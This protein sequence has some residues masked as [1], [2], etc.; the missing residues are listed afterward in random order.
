MAF[1]GMRHVVSALFNT[2]TDGSA[3]TYTSGG[4]DVGKAISGNLTIERNNNPL[5]A[6]DEIA[7]DDAG[8][9]AISLELGTDDLD[10]DVQDF[11]G[12]LV[13]K[14]A[15]SP[16]VTTYYESDKGPK[17]VGVGYMRVRR[18][19]GVTTYQGIWFYKIMFSR[20]SES[21]QTKGQSIEWKTPTITGNAIA[22]AVDG[23]GDKKFREIR[24]F[25]SASDC[26]SWLDTKAGITR[27]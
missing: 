8:V 18:K 10:E 5:Y 1:I 17:Y 12:L 27:T 7:E 6:D 25:T 24:N 22:L 3:P 2:H 20:G 11:L 16:S 21:A 23:D 26:S 13:K 19:A 15:G 14:T 4:K 9:N